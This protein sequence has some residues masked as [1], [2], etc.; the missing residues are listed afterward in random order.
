[1]FTV[2]SNIM[3]AM[4]SNACRLIVDVNHCMRPAGLGGKESA[5]STIRNLPGFLVYADKVTGAK[6]VRAIPSRPLS[7][8]PLAQP[9]S[10]PAG[11]PIDKF[12]AAG[13]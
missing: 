1:M 7:F 13:F 6:E 8:I 4:A 10:R 2:N 11:V 3:S 9:H 5:E 12:H